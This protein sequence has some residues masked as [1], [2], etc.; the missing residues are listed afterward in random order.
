MIAGVALRALQ[1]D[2]AVDHQ[3]LAGDVAGM[4]AEQKFH[5]VA[6]V[7]AG[8]FRVQHRGFGALGARAASL[9]PLPWA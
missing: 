2:T 8:T 9:M 1:R 4:I 3:H 5:G 7:P 6:D